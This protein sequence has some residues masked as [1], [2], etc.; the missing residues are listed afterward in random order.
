MVDRKLPRSHSMFL[1][2]LRC[3][4]GIPLTPQRLD[5]A[6]RRKQLTKSAICL[7]MADMTMRRDLANSEANGGK[8]I[9]NEPRV[10]AGK[11][12]IVPKT[13]VGVGG[14]TLLRGWKGAAFKG[15]TFLS[16][17]TAASGQPLTPIYLAAVNGTG[18]TGSIRPDVTGAPVYAASGRSLN[19]AAYQAPAAGRWGNAGRNSIIGPSQFVMNA[20]MQRSFGQLD[21]RFDSANVLNHVTFP[22]WNTIVG[23]AQFGL[24]NAANAMRTVRASLRVRF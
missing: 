11:H 24:P 4:G 20:S 5:C 7:T 21:V 22:N 13:G 12:S 6:I 14:G 3:P 16:Q 19:P 9:W 15:W 1:Y 10:Y 2:V 23:S 8:I 18:M 17:I